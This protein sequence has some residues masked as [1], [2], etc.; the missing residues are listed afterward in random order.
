MGGRMDIDTRILEQAARRLF[1]DLGPLDDLPQ[2]LRNTLANVY[3]KCF[4]LPKYLQDPSELLGYDNS[5]LKS[6]FQGFTQGIGE[7]LA[8]LQSAKGLITAMR[9][10]FN[11]R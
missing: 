5:S 6:T 3:Y 2:E 9:W 11:S 8:A 1:A 10:A 4:A 7:A